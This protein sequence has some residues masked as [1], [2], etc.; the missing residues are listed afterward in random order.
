MTTVTRSIGTS[1][2]DYSTLQ[3][4]EDARPAD[5]TLTRSNSVGVGST[6]STIVLD[7]GASGTDNF[8]NEHS[9]TWNAQERRIVSYVGATK[10]ATI[11]VLNGSSATWTGTPA[12]LDS[13]VVNANPQTGECYNDSE[14]TNTSV[15]L[16]ISGET[17]DTTNF[18]TLTAATGQ[19]FIDNVNVQT[20]ALT[21]N[22]TNGVG[23]R[24]TNTYANVISTNVANTRINR[25]QLSGTATR[26]VCIFQSGGS[27]QKFT[28]NI[29]H[30]DGET[31][32]LASGTTIT[33]RNNLMVRNTTNTTRACIMG[34]GTAHIVDEN[35]IVRPTNRTA[36]G[37]GIDLRYI[38]YNVRDCLI[39][40][41]TTPI[42]L[43]GN[44]AA[45]TVS[46]TGT[47]Q[48]VITGTGNI[49]SMT[50]ANEIQQPNATTGF[51][52]RAK[53]GGS[54]ID[55]GAAV[56]DAFDI[57]GT[58]R[59]AGSA[60]DMGCWELVASNSVTGTAAQV[61]IKPSQAVSAAATYNVTASAAQTL[62][63]FSQA[64]AAGISFSSTIAQVLL[65][66]TQTAATVE[67][68]IGTIAQTFAKPTQAITASITYN[69]TATAAQTLLPFSQAL[70]GVQS[71][72]ASVAQ[73]LLPFS[74]FIASASLITA[75]VSQT[76]LRP[77]QAAALYYLG[78]G[79]LAQ[80]F[81]GPSQ[82]ISATVSGPALT[83][84]AGAQRLFGPSQLL[85][86]KVPALVT[87]TQ[88]FSWRTD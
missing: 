48:T 23:L 72:S 10:T 47:D 81:F 63:L 24:I 29:M 11:G 37:T 5:L 46:N 30:S 70:A 15:L 7:V 71:F 40:G 74:Q 19:S 39:F 17:T 83:T 65:P 38:T 3:A 87:S 44:G 22:A 42:K 13:Y 14:F 28:Q 76:F 80:R 50:P 55:A 59:P 32:N 67:A 16:T 58:T 54:G 56:G 31:L 1:G 85:I 60:Y 79:V 21:Y 66:L 35:T 88:F 75:S 49:G 34:Y 18:L 57:V 53:S 20:N 25:L 64:A 73:T 8:Y 4:W 43:S 78:A 12:A 52:G 68:F 33:V 86:C 84:M 2:R 6:S 27:G 69:V 61:L 36:A 51:D 26:S 45:P 41:Y 77:T 82:A 9:V 62:L